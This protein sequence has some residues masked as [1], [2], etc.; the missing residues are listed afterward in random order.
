[1]RV[2]LRSLVQE[3]S[4]AAGLDEALV[5]LVQRVK[6]AIPVDACSV[7]LLD[8][9]SDQYVLMAAE[10]LNPAAIGQ[11]R[12]GRHDGLIGLVGERQQPINLKNAAAHP[13]YGYSPVTGEER[14]PAVLGVPLLASRRVVGVLVA[15]RQAPCPFDNEAVAFFVTLAASI[16]KVIHDA[17][18][19]GEVSRWLSAAGQETP[20]LQGIPGAP[21]VALGTLA[22]LDPLAGLESIPDRQA[23]DPAAEEAA[24]RL[25]VAAVQAELRASSERLAAVLPDETCALF[26]IYALL[27]DS[28]SLM[29]DTLQRIH[30]GDWAPGAWREAIAGHARV[31]EQMEDLYLRTRAEDIRALGERVLLQLQAKAT[32]SR[33]YPERC[34]LVGDIISITDLAAVPVER[35]AGLVCRRGSALSHTAVLARALGIPAVVSLAALPLSRV[36]GVEVMV[37]GDHGR[38]YLRPSPSVLATFQARAEATTALSAQF[39]ALRDL[40]AETLDGVRLSLYTNLGLLTDL[41]P[42]LTSGADG[43]GLY[44]TEFLFLTRTAF[45][46]EDEQYPLYRQ[47]LEAFAPQPVTLRT[48]DVGGDKILPYFPVQE[49][50]PF[51]GCRGIRFT[52]DHPEI[53]LIQLRALLRANAGLNNLQVLFPM[54][55]RVGELDEALGLLARAYR[56]LLEDGQAAAKPRV[57][58]MIEVPSAVYLVAALAKRVDFLAVGTNDLTQYLLAVDRNNADV[59]SL[60]D[61]LHPAVLSAIRQVIDGAHQQGKPVSVCGE[62]TS[63]PAAVL[64]LLGMGVDALSVYPA[65]VPR[66]KGALRR[67]T[68]SQA[69]TLLEQALG[70]EDESAVRDLLT[71]TLEAAGLG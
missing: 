51:L 48:L 67:W 33:P 7:Y 45:P 46:V 30:N 1:M 64:L 15:Y 39:S 17:R 19:L 18:S 41:A 56:D 62:M 54:I 43:V 66:V 60:Y 38:L 58:V 69:R 57:G 59:A 8:A 24:F 44:R 49:E 12:L 68:Q 23:Q 28:D 25:A 3:I 42:A 4:A 21:G 47:V 9:V 52:L 22:L 37:D 20:F 29:A 61:S 71:S 55:S 10:G 13:R 40:P 53:L 5:L 11:V 50:N 35:L 36:D 65:S 70:L 32:A 27:L 6:A 26:D 31:F 16:A 14:Y 2:T 63:D 34:I